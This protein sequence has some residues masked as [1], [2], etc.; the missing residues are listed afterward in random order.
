MNP[1]VTGYRPRRVLVSLVLALVLLASGCG[2]PAAISDQASNDL[3]SR[4]AQLREAAEAEDRAAARQ[5]IN[6]LL[7]ALDRWQEAGEISVERADEIRERLATV[8]AH[9]DLL[10]PPAPATPVT[11][12][13]DDDDEDDHEGGKQK[14]EE[15][16]KKDKEE[17][18]QRGPRQRGHQDVQTFDLPRMGGSVLLSRRLA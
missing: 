11:V 16:G 14:D 1:H 3:R 12:D 18:G 9:L 15:E 4:A 10:P 8:D 17:D 7:V 13:D 5:A 6:E 2:S